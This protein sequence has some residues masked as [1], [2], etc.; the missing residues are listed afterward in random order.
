[1]SASLSPDC[2]RAGARSSI[3]TAMGRRSATMKG[4]NSPVSGALVGPGVGLGVGS[5][6]GVGTG[7]MVGTG[8]G[9][10]VAVATGVGL[11]VGVAGGWVG[12]GPPDTWATVGMLGDGPDAE[13][14]GRVSTPSATPATMANAAPRTTMPTGRR[15]NG[16]LCDRSTGGAGHPSWLACRGTGGQDSASGGGRRQ[17]A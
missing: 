11:G 14:P 9:V 17:V 8:V 10:G 12:A 3:M 6:V 16:P 13:V 2:G 7:G 15:P 4:T 1:M 5:G